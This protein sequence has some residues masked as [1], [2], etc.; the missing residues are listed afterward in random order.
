LEAIRIQLT[1][2]MSQRYSVWY[3]VHA[4]KFGW[5]GWACDGASAGTEGYAYRLEALQVLILPKG[6]AAP[7]STSNSF[8]KKNLYASTLNQM[9]KK[10]TAS[11]LRYVY[12]DVYG[13]SNKE[14]ICM[15]YNPGGNGMTKTLYVYTLSKGAAKLMLKHYLLCS[16]DFGYTFYKNTGGLDLHEGSTGRYGQQ[17]T[18]FVA[19][20]GAYKKVAHRF[21]AIGTS[22]WRYSSNYDKSVTPIAKGNTVVLGSSVTW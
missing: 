12:A 10:S 20:K 13:D 14:L 17:H 11:K 3:R 22:S 8:K 1:G 21:L 18:I 16:G 19:R 4:Q 15:V 5:M 7:G 6:S 2:E 9:K